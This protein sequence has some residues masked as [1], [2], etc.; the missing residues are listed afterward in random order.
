MQNNENKTENRLKI[1]MF[2]DTFFPMVDGVVMVVDNYARRLSKYCD[3]TVFTV[4]P[5]GEST[6][7]EFPYKVVRCKKMMVPFLDYDLPLPNLDS[8]FVKELKNTKLD[9]VHIHSPF[10]MGRVGVDYAK[11]SHIP[12]VASLHSQYDQDFYRVTKNK[13]ITKF[14]VKKMMN[15]FN[16]C[17][18]YYAVNQRIAEVFKG[19]GAKHMPKVQC[20]ATDFVPIVDEQAALDM[21]NRKFNLDPN[22]PVFLFVGR[23]NILKNIYF[24]LEALEK[25]DTRYFK[26]IFVGVGQDMDDFKESVEHSSVKDNVIFTGK[27]TDRELLRALYFRAKLFLFPSLYDSNSLVQ[28]EAAS[29][30]T[31]TVFIQGSATSSTVTD[32]VNGFITE[33]TT[34]AFAEKIMKVLSDEEYYKKVQEGAFRDLY[35]TW[36]EKV[37]EMYEKYLEIIAQKKLQNE[38]QK[39]TKISAEKQRKIRKSKKLKEVRKV[40][41]IQKN[42]KRKQNRAN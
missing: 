14:L 8:K 1:G 5:R 32:D 23:I 40:L 21:V 3:V 15:V 18:E 16:N 31:P 34:I 25:L 2:V 35:A 26:M 13:S 41:R 9:I 12:A 42:E 19:Y 27:I 33:P 11:K 29:Q 17:D 7:M 20:N 38:A 36:D 10:T 6:K 30:K 24:I 4:N 39:N 22:M 28:I 37:D